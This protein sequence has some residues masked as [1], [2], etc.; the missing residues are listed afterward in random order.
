[1]VKSRTYIAIPPGATIKE[2]LIDRHLSQKEFAIRMNLSQK[3]VSKLI[4]GDVQLTSD[5]AN[6]LELVL[7]VPATFWNN[8]ESIYREK[9]TK[10]LAENEM[11]SDIEIIKK[12]PY[13]EMEKNEWIP[14]T[15]NMKERVV[16]LRKFFEVVN[17]SL[18]MD[19]SLCNIACRRLNE[20]EKS[21]YALLAWAQKAKLEA[22][23]METSSV[24]IN[25]LRKRISEIREMTIENP[26]EFIEKLKS[27]LSKCGIALVFLPH[28]GGSYLHG[29]T[30]YDGK[31]I[32]IGITLR[33]KVADK[34]W[35]SLFHEIGHI[36]L[37][38]IENGNGTS[39]QDE[40]DADA[41][42]QDI[43]IH[44]E[45][46]NSFINNNSFSEESIIEFSHNIGIA[47]GILVGRLQKDAYI[48]YNAYNDLKINY[49]M[50]A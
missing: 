42:A 46:Y 50:D 36:V 49:S 48:P 12:L 33:G 30:F 47:P 40:K 2:Q 11:E 3:H 7:G 29:A 15:K 8:L 19:A 17:L 45:D 35:F 5:V 10:A 13:K 32:V 25:I 37:G 20:T 26:D 22:R 31:K 21:D 16:N 43:L 34:F 1:M 39:E 6:R 4:N 44:P 18:I 41:F 24:D 27:I 28:I 14:A 9:L 38:H 23:E